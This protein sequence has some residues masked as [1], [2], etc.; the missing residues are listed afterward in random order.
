MVTIKNI[1]ILSFLDNLVSAGG[2]ILSSSQILVSAAVPEI[3]M[4][5][6]C[7]TEQIYEVLP[8]DT[9]PLMGSVRLRKVSVSGRFDCTD[10]SWG[11]SQCLSI[12][13]VFY[14]RR[15]SQ[16]CSIENVFFW[17]SSHAVPQYRREHATGIPLSK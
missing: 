9:F 15:S 5:T 11:S 2:T 4:R 16:C 7:S 8:V 17:E 3:A 13:T 14:F 1:A 12:D 10:L 6:W